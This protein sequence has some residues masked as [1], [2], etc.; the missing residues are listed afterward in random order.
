MWKLALLSFVGVSQA[1]KFSSHRRT[2]PGKLFVATELTPEVVPSKFDVSAR[3]PFTLQEIKQA[4]PKEL[5]IKDTLKSMTYLVKDV[6]VVAALALAVTKFG[7]PITWPLYWFAQGTM[8]WALFVVGHDCGHG[9]FSDSAKVN[10]LVGLITH[11][12]ILVPFAGWQISHRTHHSNHGNVDT[13]ESWYPLSKTNYDN[14]DALGK[15][16]RYNPLG[17]L[18]AYPVYLWARTP[19]KTGSHF[20]PNCDLFKPSEKNHVLTSTAGYFAMLGL[21]GLIGSKIGWGMLGALYG[22]PYLIGT[23]WLSV[24]TYLHHT[25]PE[26]PWYRGQ[27]WNYMRGGLSTRDRDYG[28]FN[29]I[30]HNIGTHVVHHLFP[31]IP[32]YNIVKATEYIKP[33]IGEYFIEPEKSG[34][35]PFHLVSQWWKGVRNCKYVDDQGEVLSYKSETNSGFDFSR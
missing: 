9:S 1:F 29:G 31:Q 11:S 18:V 21:L 27:E 7:N 10:N 33:V 3:P 34:I 20:D 15:L 2:L 14:C 13:D 28:I 22:I 19:P 5:F 25:D 35:L 32:H 6:A 12:S 4:I 26:V 23:A 16:G 30:H 17:M 24:V 8:F